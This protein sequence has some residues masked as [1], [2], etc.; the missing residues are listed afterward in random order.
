MVLNL[1]FFTS[2]VGYEALSRGNKIAALCVKN[3]VVRYESKNDLY[4]GWPAN[5]RAKE[6]FGPTVLNLV[7]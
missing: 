6:D 7:R 2:T 5:L 4:F 1:L 3:E